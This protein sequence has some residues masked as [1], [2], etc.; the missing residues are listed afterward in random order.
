MLVLYGIP[1]TVATAA[2]LAYPA[3][4]LRV[5]ALLGTLAFILLRRQIASGN[6]RHVCRAID[7]LP[8]K[9]ATLLASRSSP[10]LR[11]SVT[12]LGVG[13]RWSD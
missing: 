10:I 9:E 5:P 8:D 1:S 13:R 7:C 6:W 12:A 4:A 3:I 11:S 2:A